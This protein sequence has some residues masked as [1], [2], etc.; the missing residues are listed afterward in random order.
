MRGTHANIKMTIYRRGGP[1]RGEAEDL[2][3]HVGVNRN[4]GGSV[5][6]NRD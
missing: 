1:G 4:G 3:D 6:A 5:V 2:V